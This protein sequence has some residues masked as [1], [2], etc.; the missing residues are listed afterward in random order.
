VYINSFY[1]TNGH[2]LIIFDIYINITI[3]IEVDVHWFV[4]MLTHLSN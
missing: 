4:I 2:I 1:I 3:N